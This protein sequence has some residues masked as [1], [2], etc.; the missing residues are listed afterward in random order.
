LAKKRKMM[1][2]D[3]PNRDKF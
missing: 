3:F 2:E 1:G